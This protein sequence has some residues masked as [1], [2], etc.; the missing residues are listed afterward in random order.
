METTVI[1]G[2]CRCCASVGAFKDVKR[3]YHWMGEEEIYGEM[4]KECFDIDVS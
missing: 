4:L 2:M 3:S 1:N